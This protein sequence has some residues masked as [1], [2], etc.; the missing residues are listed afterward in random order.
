MTQNGIKLWAPL[1]QA[2]MWS[3]LTA[4]QQRRRVL[5]AS[6]CVSSTIAALYADLVNTA[7]MSFCLH[8]LEGTGTG[9]FAVGSKLKSQTSASAFY[10]QINVY[11]IRPML[12][13]QHKTQLPASG[14]MR[15]TEKK[16]CPW[17]PVWLHTYRTCPPPSVALSVDACLSGLRLYPRSVIQNDSSEAKKASKTYPGAL[18]ISHLASW[19]GY[20]LERWISEDESV[21]SEVCGRRGHGFWHWFW[22]AKKKKKKKQTHPVP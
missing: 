4:S 16:I 22:A 3:A 17:T 11:G 21:F 12:L 8:Q 18:K 15:T 7:Y 10:S 1:V 6:E 14:M 13:P 20:I 19:G 9:R 2:S 5:F